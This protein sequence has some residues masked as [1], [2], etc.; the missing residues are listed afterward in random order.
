MRRSI[1][2]LT[3]ASLAS[4]GLLA[5]CSS[6]NNSGNFDQPLDSTP[7]APM[8][9]NPSALIRGRKVGR[10]TCAIRRPPTTTAI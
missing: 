3:V 2:C 9:A 4:L 8:T 7:T 6:T 10:R 5:A 1:S